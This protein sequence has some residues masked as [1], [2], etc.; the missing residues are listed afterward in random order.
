MDAERKVRDEIVE[1]MGESFDALTMAAKASKATYEDQ[2]RTIATLT[3]SNAELTATIK[4]L[5][6]KISTLA[7]Q[8]TAAAK[9]E[10]QVPLPPGFQPTDAADT[11]SAANSAGIF[12]STHKKKVQCGRVFE[13][14]Q[15][16]NSVD[17]VTRL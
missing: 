13:F 10:D 14:L 15:A 8:V 9:K 4:H 5:T 11:G 7:G 1:R 6:N 2:S 16:S 17:I 12:M 3:Q